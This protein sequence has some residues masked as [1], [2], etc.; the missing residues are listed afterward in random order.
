MIR[1]KFLEEHGLNF[2]PNA[3]KIR[4]LETINNFVELNPKEF[5]LRAS[6]KIASNHNIEVS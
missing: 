4:L 3:T 5:N 2:P 6:E 1:T